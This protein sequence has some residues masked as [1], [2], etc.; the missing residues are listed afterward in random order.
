[1]VVF[2]EVFWTI[3]IIFM[4][5]QGI[6]VMVFA[7]WSDILQLMKRQRL[8]QESVSLQKHER[9]ATVNPCDVWG[10]NR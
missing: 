3:E 6:F 10:K 4:K 8:I 1:M 5:T 2:D 7:E 9:C